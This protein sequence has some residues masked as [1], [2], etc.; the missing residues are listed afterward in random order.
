MIS[1][2]LKWI[3]NL[4]TLVL[5][6]TLIVLV[7]FAASSKL[8]G[9]NP[10]IFGYELMTVMSGSMEPTFLTGSVIAIETLS[11]P[12]DLKAG[13]VVTYESLDDA[14]VLITHRIISVE[15]TDNSVEYTTKGD[16]ND[17]A[18]ANPIPSEHVVGLYA[19]VTIPYLGYVFYFMHSSAGIATFLIIPGILLI[20]FSMTT[21]W[22]AFS[23][24]EQE[25]KRN[26]R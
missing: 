12:T 13:D 8:S 21:V 3:S 4:I 10:T 14:S 11:N 15:A 19:N 23:K 16:H 18:D 17:T 2:L 9:G 6:L 5:V 26:R 24:A 20:L 1:K 25:P 22:K 7:Y